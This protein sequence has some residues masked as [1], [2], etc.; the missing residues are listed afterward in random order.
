MALHPRRQP[1]R[2]RRAGSASC[3]PVRAGSEQAQAPWCDLERL[4]SLNSRPDRMDRPTAPG[5]QRIEDSPLSKV[6]QPPWRDCSKQHSSYF[7][8][9]LLVHKSARTAK[10]K[11]FPFWDVH[12]LAKVTEE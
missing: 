1:E 2:I 3:L 6:A 10:V 4:Q 11:H 7:G 9:L 5:P 8:C 12:L